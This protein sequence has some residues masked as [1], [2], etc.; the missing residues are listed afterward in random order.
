M[1][2]PCRPLLLSPINPIFHLPMRQFNSPWNGREN[3]FSHASFGN[4]INLIPDNGMMLFLFDIELFFWGSRGSSQ[5]HHGK[6]GEKTCLTFHLYTKAYE[7]FFCYFLVYWLNTQHYASLCLLHWLI[8][9]EAAFLSA[10]VSPAEFSFVC[11]HRVIIKFNKNIPP[12][13]LDSSSL[14]SASCRMTVVCLLIYELELCI[15]ICPR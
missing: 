9:C 6:R 4:I 2:K 3:P 8:I 7:H 15:M 5:F 11:T 1:E 13:W 10:I 14:I 12:P